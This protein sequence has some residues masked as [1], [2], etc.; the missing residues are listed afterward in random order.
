[1]GAA[2]DMLSAA[3]LELLPDRQRFLSEFN[4][5][6]IPN[7][8]VE[9]EPSRKCGILGTHLKVCVAGNEEE[10]DGYVADHHHDHDHG[11]EHEQGSNHHHGHDHEH[12]H[13]VMHQ[14]EHIVEE[15]P[16]SAKVKEDILGIYGLL[17]AAES[18]VHGVPVSEIHFHEVGTMDALADITLCCLLVEKIAA[19]RIVASP[20][21][22][23]SGTVQC[24]HGILPVPAPATAV[25]L[26]GIPVF[27]GDIAYELCTP[28][29]AALLKYFVKEFC[30]MPGMVIE[31]TGYGMGK[32]DFKVANCVRAVLGNAVESEEDI[33][34]L[35]CNLDDMTAEEIGFAVTALMELGA[36][37]VY[38]SAIGMKKNRPGTLLCVLANLNDKER[39]TKEIFR[40]TTTLGVRASKMSRTVLTRREI[41]EDTLYGPVRY[42]ISQGQGVERRKAEYED[43][44]RIAAEKNVSVGDARMLV[45]NQDR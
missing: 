19:D 11:H 31:K 24:A 8:T 38:T 25:L 33:W 5:L 34:E 44:A 29:G 14:I 42:K 35:R 21:R 23:G 41:T 16:V 27:A 10:T 37:D 15:M 39:M 32:K 7:V 4:S 6:K 13:G 17:A 43:L 28:T 45:E 22:T 20:V 1:M 36:L 18:R 26:E 3:L 30:S 12:I 2:G 9:D 40:F